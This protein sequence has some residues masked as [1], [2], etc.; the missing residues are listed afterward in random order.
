MIQKNFHFL[1][2]ALLLVLSSSAYAQSG[3]WIRG[4][5][6]AQPE[7]AEAITTDPNTGNVYI[8]GTF[9][10]SMNVDGNALVNLGGTD[11]FVAAYD[12]SGSLLWIDR[13]GWGSSE[14]V[15]GIELDGL[16]HLLVSGEYQDSTIIGTDTIYTWFPGGNFDLFCFQL[17]LNGGFNWNVQTQG[18]GS[19]FLYDIDTDGS[20]NTY[21]VGKFRSNLELGPDSLVQFTVPGLED[22]FVTKIS[23]AGSFIWSIRAGGV[24]FD[25]GTDISVW[26]DSIIAIAGWFQ[27]TCYFRDSTV[28][29]TSEQLK[30]VFVATYDSSGS[31]K[32][33]AGGTGNGTDLVTSVETSPTGEI[34]VSGTFDSTFTMA[35]Q[36]FTSQGGF[37]IFLAKYAADGTPMWIRQFGSTEFETFNDISLSPSG[38]LIATGYFQG[39][40][41]IDGLTVSSGDPANQDIVVAAFDAGGT[42]QWMRNMGGK[43]IDEGRAI[44]TDSDGYIYVSGNFADS[45]KFYQRTLVSNGADDFFVFRMAPDGS[46]SID[47]KAVQL[48]VT[49]YP[50]PSNSQ[51]FFEYE[52]ERSGE[53][54]VDIYDLQGSLLRTKNTQ[55]QGLRG[56]V[57]M[58]LGDLP[59]GMYLWRMSEGEKTAQGRLILQH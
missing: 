30:D 58:T 37:D 10:D 36:T 16:G 7:F 2:F 57:E 51:V 14:Y 25:A 38:E 19:E 54:K 47:P 34:Y 48:S 41:T 31:F 18:S 40:L 12:S 43:S 3:T 11:I 42:A 17:D 28:F 44:K 46:V 45:C 53:V 4:G 29:L 49:Q 56:R 1:L 22:I 9:K 15:H 6:G 33:V 39:D 52:L 50:N 32:W 23:P 13:H 5:G 21:G 35:G 24:K 26:N 20:G 27:D 55:A 8:A 59:A